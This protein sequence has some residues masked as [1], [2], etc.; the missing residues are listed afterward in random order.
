MEKPVFPDYSEQIERIRVLWNRARN[1]Y[2]S[3]FAVLDEVRSEIGDERFAAWCFHELHISLSILNNTSAIL[4]SEDAA[5]VRDK[6]KRAKEYANE[7]RR[8]AKAEREEEA[9]QRKEAAVLAQKEADKLERRQQR[10]EGKVLQIDEAV[11]SAL[12]S[13]L[14]GDLADALAECRVIEKQSRT[15]LGKHYSFMKD[16]VK[17]KRA[18]KD[19]NGRYWNWSTWCAA[20]ITCS[21]QYA[22]RCIAEFHADIAHESGNS[23]S[24][25]E[26]S[27]NASATLLH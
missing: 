19:Q 25:S 24:I 15:A 14:P 1:M 27:K 22:D 16:A 12:I 10:R 4:K 20:M 2:S 7:Q 23:V 8:A 9:R 17:A 26:S 11:R 13:N 3:A 6:N 21:K 18:G 5:I